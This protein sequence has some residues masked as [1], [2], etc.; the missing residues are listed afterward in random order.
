MICWER[1]AFGLIFACYRQQ[2]LAMAEVKSTFALSPGMKAPAFTLPDGDGESHSLNSLATGKKAVVVVF[3]CNHCPFVVHLA[4]AVG[5]CAAEYEEE[6]VQFIAINANDVSAYPADAPEE[7][8]DFAREYDWTFP[9]LYDESQEIA[10]AY[11]AACTPDFYVFDRKLS[12]VY[13]GQFD[14]SRPGNSE[15]VTGDDLR[16]VLDSIVSGREYM[17]DA[18]PSSGC[19]IKWKPG[20]E[21][22]YFG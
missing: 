1:A 20:N 14:S 18:R 2:P 21:P 13:A 11:S 15:P 7:M 10:K 8:G 4:E 5:E 9:Y 22:S 3:A 17:G 16:E 19:N 12:L 6:G